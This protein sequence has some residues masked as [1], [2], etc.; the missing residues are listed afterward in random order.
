MQ[1]LTSPRRRPAWTQLDGTIQ[2]LFGY[3]EESLGLGLDD[4]DR[5]AHGGVADPAVPND[6]D[7]QLYDVAVAIFRGPPIP[8]TTSS[9]MEMQMWPGNFL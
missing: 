2:N 5:N 4:P 9:L 6:A 7:V 8:C 3:G 1:A